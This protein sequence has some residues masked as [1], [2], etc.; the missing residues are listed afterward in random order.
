M[1]LSFDN[2]SAMVAGGMALVPNLREQLV[3]DALMKQREQE[4]QWQREDRAA[5]AAAAE[6]AAQQQAAFQ[7]DLE[8]ALLSG[9]PRKIMA[10]R[11]RHPEFAKGMKDA[12]DAL[13]EDTRRTNLTQIGT[14]F[15][16]ANAG[17]AKGAADV[18]RQRIEDDRKVGMADPQD[19]AILAE[20][21]SGD[22]QRVRAASATIGIQLA[23]VE[24][25]K[26]SETYGK[27]NPSE[28]KPGIQRE[29]EYYRSIGRNDL[30]D[31][32]LVNNADPLVQV[33]GPYGV[34]VRPRS[35]VLGA[36][37]QGSVPAAQGGGDPSG[38]GAGMETGS[39]WSYFDLDG[40][41]GA[42]A[43]T[44]T[45][46]VRVRT[47]Q[48]VAALPRGARFIDPRDGVTVREKP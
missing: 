8:D 15:A 20:L 45:Q 40:P 2:D 7:Q 30:A 26:F 27:L 43:R 41:E 38:S 36:A 48:D 5:Q 4:F 37:P 35:Q 16:R 21:E 3:Q 28:A 10:L 24:P 33:S 29:V 32:L 6:K 22:P 18:L 47:Q 1:P 25:D 31:Q 11:F 23:A 13:D 12:F 17:D 44:K 39:F 46:P 9:D 14:I 34:D 42:V 19:E